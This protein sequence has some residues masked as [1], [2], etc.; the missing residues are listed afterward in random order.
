[1]A[2]KYTNSTP[3]CA[4]SAKQLLESVQFFVNGYTST[5]W[6]NVCKVWN[7]HNNSSCT[8]QIILSKEHFAHN[9]RIKM[10]TNAIHKLISLQLC[11]CR[12]CP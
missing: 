1:M 10:K 4:K 2:D 12:Y 3:Q 8:C 7:G 9:E 11:F 5:Q 6:P